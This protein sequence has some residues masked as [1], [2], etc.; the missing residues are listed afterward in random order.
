LGIQESIIEALENARSEAKESHLWWSM[1]IAM[2][3]WL[4]EM[5]LH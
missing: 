4:S 5:G 3:H 2:I 1:I